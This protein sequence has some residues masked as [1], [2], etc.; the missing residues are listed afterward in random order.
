M[1]TF[2]YKA[3]DRGGRAQQGFLEAA[4]ASALAND[5]RNR[6]WLSAAGWCC[7]SS[8]KSIERLIT[9]LQGTGLDAQSN[10]LPLEDLIAKPSD[11]AAAQF[12]WQ[13]I[14]GGVNLEAG[15]H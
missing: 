2:Q 7:Q 5:L 8:D 11:G 12:E 1:P 14:Y 15:R 4:S 6:G 10:A 9:Q 13:V 3:R